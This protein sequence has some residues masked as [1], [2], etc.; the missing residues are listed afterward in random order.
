MDVQRAI[1]L[2]DEVEFLLFDA[3]AYDRAAAKLVDLLGATD[4]VEALRPPFDED[5]AALATARWRA[6]RADGVIKR[7][8]GRVSADA[9]FRAAYGLSRRLGQ[10]DLARRSL[11]GLAVGQATTGRYRAAMKTQA[12]LARF[13]RTDSST[14]ARNEYLRRA[15]D[16]AMHLDSPE[17]AIA[18]TERTILP[19]VE[20]GL[21]WVAATHNALGRFHAEAAARSSMERDR[22]AHVRK[23]VEHLEVGRTILDGYRPQHLFSAA[24]YL[25]LARIHLT[26][27]D[28]DPASRYLDLARA[29]Y[30]RIGT[31]DRHLEPIA[32]AVERRPRS[33]PNSLPVAWAK[34]ALLRRNHPELAAKELFSAIELVLDQLARHCRTPLPKR[35][36]GSMYARRYDEAR[37]GLLDAAA[38]DLETLLPRSLFLQELVRPRN[39]IVH[40]VSGAVDADAFVRS[41]A[42]AL[43]RLQ[44]GCPDWI[45]QRLDGRPIAA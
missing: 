1:E 3:F 20:D 12:A 34:S 27:G 38:I 5:E 4:H 7:D 15:A 2:A 36:R 17:A 23:S 6:L 29:S 10:P 8:A 42:D 25:G 19:R 37:Q 35:R 14:H 30:R 9:S 18:I 22:L 44:R 43:D 41:L 32:A 21:G 16:V 13:L 39:E 11:N 26:I 31:S 28:T 24:N 40:N 33:T 45:L